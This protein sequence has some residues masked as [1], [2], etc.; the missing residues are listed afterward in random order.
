MTILPKAVYKL[1]VIPIKLHKTLFTELE[2]ISLKFILNHKRPRFTKAIL[3]GKNKAGGI[4][5]PN[6][7]QYYKRIV[8]KPA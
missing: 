7:R 2:Q 1:N 6:F 3:G 4:T 5:L 8:I